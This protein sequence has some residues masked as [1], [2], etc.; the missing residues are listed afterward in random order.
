MT[1]PPVLPERRAQKL[2]TRE[3]VLRVAQR[4]FCELGVEA[5]TVDQIAREAG[6]SRPNFYLHFSGKEEVLH[7]LRREMWRMAQGFYEDFAQLPDTSLQTLRAWVDRVACAWR[8]DGGITRIVL[9]ATPQA[10][11]HEYQQNLA[12][13][14]DAVT[15]D[16]N[17]WRTFSRAES[18]ARAY[19]LIVQL[20]RCMNDQDH[21]DLPVDRE[22]LLDTLAAV[23]AAT[24][25][26]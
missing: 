13:Y 16:A 26:R 14:V 21:I 19:L 4:L 17:K 18:R 5:T 11:E 9:G 6:T 25:V 3:R 10:V 8:R 1:S 7:V 12:Q 2:D 24:L 20:E 23:W 15:S 22:A